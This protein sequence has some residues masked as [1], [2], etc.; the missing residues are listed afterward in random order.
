MPRLCVIG[1]RSLAERP[2]AREPAALSVMNGIDSRGQEHS[3]ACGL[4]RADLG[5]TSIAISAS[6]GRVMGWLRA[7]EYKSG[8]EVRLMSRIGVVWSA[9]IL[10]VVLGLGGPGY[11]TT[12]AEVGRYHQT[13]RIIH[14]T[15]AVVAAAGD[16]TRAWFFGAS[17][18]K[19][20]WP[21]GNKPTIQHVVEELLAGGIN[22][23]VMVVNPHK[24]GIKEHFAPAG[25]R[26]EA[27]RSEAAEHAAAA[28][29]HSNAQ[30]LTE[31]AEARKAAMKS[32]R[33]TDNLIHLRDLGHHIEYID[34][35]GDGYGN[36]VPAKDAWR[37]D[38]TENEPFVFVWPDDVVL[39]NHADHAFTKDLLAAYGDQGG[40]PLIGVQEVL[41]HEVNAYGIVAPKGDGFLLRD[42]VEK[43]AVGEAPSV[44]AD[45]G[46]MVLTPDFMT[47]L[48]ANGR[49][50]G[51]EYYL[52]DGVKEFLSQGHQF[53]YLATAAPQVWIT[54]GDAR[55]SLLGNLKLME[56]DPGAF[57]MT[58]QEAADALTKAQAS[59]VAMSADSERP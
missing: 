51:G 3:Y 20:M 47:V 15:T 46:R 2:P 39:P 50:T 22:R 30:R 49:G 5:P 19:E 59:L 7:K 55:N 42:I 8:G 21:L 45:F 1:S 37:A 11:A 56:M 35:T 41:P 40:V 34:Q 10:L 44:Y 27:Y 6:I 4:L 9:A 17:T 32:Q 16:G 26:I 29:E 36:A 48:M 33:L 14:P 52:V 43:P 18:Q 38:A 54:M 53:G 12:P 28:N 23:I 57:D 31:A 24:V 58:P 25:S 13:S